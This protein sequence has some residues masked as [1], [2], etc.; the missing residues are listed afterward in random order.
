MNI[1]VRV[2]TNAKKREIKKEEGYFR[3][4]LTS[5]PVEGKANKELIE[6]LS[7]VFG[8]KKSGIRIIRGEKDKIKI[9]SIPD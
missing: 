9:I 1:E 5:Q 7:E 2:T 6:Y 8:V 4:R 3:V